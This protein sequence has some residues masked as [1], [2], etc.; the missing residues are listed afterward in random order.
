MDRLS[1]VF[2][3]LLGASL[4][5]VCA[6]TEGS[7]ERYL[8]KLKQDAATQGIDQLILDK[9]FSQIKLFKKASNDDKTAPNRQRIWSTISPRRSVRRWW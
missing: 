4:T 9:A 5:N 3:S 8:D 6:A 7:F 1:L 2:I